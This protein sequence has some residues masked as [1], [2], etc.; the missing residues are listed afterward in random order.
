MVASGGRVE[1]E[2]LYNDALRPRPGGPVE[3]Q[4]LEPADQG[5]VAP[6]DEQ[7]SGD[8]RHS[9]GGFED[10][11]AGAQVP[12]VG[13]VLVHGVEPA[14]G[15]PCEVEGQAPAAADI[16]DPGEHM[17]NDGALAGSG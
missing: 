3:D 10:G 16:P 11:R 8:L 5:L 15:R 13:V 1:C 4:S 2:W 7:A 17:G 9:P 12:G 14:A 6:G